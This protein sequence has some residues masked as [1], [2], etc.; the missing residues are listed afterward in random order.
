MSNELR[1]AMQIAERESRVTRSGIEWT[2]MRRNWPDIAGVAE[3][4]LN[5]RLPDGFTFD[6]EL[7]RQPNPLESHL[8]DLER[9]HR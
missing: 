8:L 7:R 4:Y 2:H 6:H 3:T 9:R 1:L 5:A